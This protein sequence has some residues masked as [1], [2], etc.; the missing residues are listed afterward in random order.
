MSSSSPNDSSAS[1]SARCISDGASLRAIRRRP[2]PCA[3]GLGGDGCPCG[4]VAPRLDDM[5]ATASRKPKAATNRTALRD[6][7][8][9]LNDGRPEEYLALFRPDATLHGFPA[10]IED[11]EDLVPLPRRHRRHVP[12]RDRDARRR[13]RRARPR[14]HALHLARQRRAGLGRS[15]PRAA[16]SCA[17]TTARSPSAGTCRRRSTPSRPS[18]GADEILAAVA[19]EEAAMVELLAELVEAPT[20]L[21]REAGR[22]GGHAAGV[23]RARAGAVRRAARARA[24]SSGTPAARRSAGTSPARP[25]SSPT[26]A[27]RADGRSLILNGHIDVVSPEP[28]ALWTGDPFDAARATA[29]GSTAAARAT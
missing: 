14:R 3:T 21:G 19:A 29:S 18:L 27:R 2:K 9:A 7:V 24:R 6:A 15:V 28:G 20:L 16:R 26:G 17:S 11:V 25:T 23:R 22:A 13:R 1:R 5:T 4:D 12:G 10:G 8:A